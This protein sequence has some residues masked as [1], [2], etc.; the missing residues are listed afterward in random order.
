ML[1]GCAAAALGGAWQVAT[2]QSTT[3][4]GLEP[5]DLTLLRYVVPALLLLPALATLRGRWRSLDPRVVAA[6][7]IG[8]GL[9]FG[10]LA[11]GGSRLAP[12]A[13]M[14]V[15][16]AGASPLLAALFAWLL[17]RERPGGLRAA[18]LLLVAVGVAALGLP[19]FAQQGST[20][21]GDA[22][23]LGAA[24]LWAAFALAFRR[25]GLTPWQGAAL[26]H[27]ASALL[28]L[29]VFAWNGLGTL[30]S[31]AAGQLAW[32]IVWQSVVAGLAG[33]ALFMMAIERLGAAPAAAFGALAPVVSA[34]GGWWW[35]GEPLDA[36]GW[37]AVAAT[38]LGVAFASG[39]LDRRI[40]VT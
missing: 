7:V 28:L 17:W 26:V 8:G 33:V 38:A 20:P 4:G 12:A 34:L 6:L 13:H 27:A 18:G 10:L 31:A 32:A 36:W 25:S 11:I 35:L 23:F 19:A 5:L 22:M 37:A 9:P 30:A 2:R 1:A 15:L 40:A 21:L 39:A 14:G 3:A 16:V 24:A 29:P